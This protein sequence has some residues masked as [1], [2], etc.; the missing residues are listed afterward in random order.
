MNDVEVSQRMQHPFYK[1]KIAWLPI[2]I[3]EKGDEHNSTKLAMRWLCFLVTDAMSVGLDFSS[4]LD[5]NGYHARVGIPYINFHL[6]IPF[7]LRLDMWAH[8]Y[9]WRAGARSYFKWQR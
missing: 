4:E 3:H 9:L 6:R 1:N 7:P 5:F 8:R 2:F